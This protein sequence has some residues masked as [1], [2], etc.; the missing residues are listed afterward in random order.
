[1]EIY[2][3][4]L[5]GIIKGIRN[6]D[7]LSASFKMQHQ[8]HPSQTF[9]HPLP[10]WASRNAFTNLSMILKLLSFKLKNVFHIVFYES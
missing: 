4:S 1:M 2:P 8:A 3:H 5:L 9:L 7:F 6:V 10:F